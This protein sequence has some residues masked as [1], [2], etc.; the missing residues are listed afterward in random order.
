MAKGKKCHLESVE[1]VVPDDD[2]GAAAG[3]PALAG[4]DGLDAGDGGRRV[5]AR[6]QG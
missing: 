4:R 5:Q 3:G 1:E 2:D 6:V